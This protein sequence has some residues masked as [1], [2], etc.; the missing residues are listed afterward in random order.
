M[1]YHVRP[2]CLATRSPKEL[3]YNNITT[4]AWNYKQLINKIPHYKI[5]E[6]YY[7]CNLIANETPIQC[8]VHILH[9]DI[10]NHV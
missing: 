4:K 5:R 2:H 3:I 1:K 7:N 6:L 9:K 10:A 8:N